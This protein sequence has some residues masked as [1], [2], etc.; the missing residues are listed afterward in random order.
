MDF[1]VFEKLKYN[2]GKQYIYSNFYIFK[3][4][5]RIFNQTVVKL[6]GINYN[7]LNW[8]CKFDIC[9]VTLIFSEKYAF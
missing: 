3:K 2:V 8:K 7:I 9:I 4:L 6:K 5:S 1:F